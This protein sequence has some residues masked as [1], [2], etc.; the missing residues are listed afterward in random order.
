MNMEWW[1]ILIIIF[2]GLGLLIMTRLPVAFAFLL[3][4]IIGA[5]FIMG[6]VGGLRQLTLGIATSLGTFALIPIPLFVFL[7]EIVFHSK[8]APVALDTL[9]KWLG[10]LPGRLSLLTMGSSAMFGALS[11]SAMATTAMLGTVMTP[12]MIKRGYDKSMIIGPIICGG[13]LAMIIPPSGVAVLLGAIAGISI[14]RLLISGIIPG[15]LIAGLFIIYI[16]VRCWL[17]P[18]LAPAYEVAPSP[19]RERVTLLLRNVVPLGLIFFMAVGVILLG[20]ATPS[21]AA[22]LACL[23]ALALAAAYRTLSLEVL[24]KS[25]SGTVRVT[26]MIFMILAG[27]LTFSQLLA[28]TGAT[29]GL[30]QAVTELEV[31]PIFIIIS[32]ELVVLFLGFFIDALSI[33]MISIPI[34]MPIVNALGFDEIAFGLLILV[35][36]EMG[37]ETPPFGLSLFVFKA[38][39]PPEI[40]MGNIYR[41]ILPFVL[42]QLVAVALINIFP[43]IATW[44]PSLMR[45]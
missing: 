5:Y 2:G 14:G 37:Q 23:V 44:L 22:A 20:I 35:L 11:G 33:M 13:S 10:K 17:N 8:M 36:L 41:A 40:T 45:Q 32:M 15:L 30:I 4:N 24:K 9:G 29:R 34:F 31:A 1:L 7:G 38:V 39:A 25:V 43:T 28:F 21:E 16:A 42:V 19:L 6:G 26:A 3:T 18:S 12:E 27:S